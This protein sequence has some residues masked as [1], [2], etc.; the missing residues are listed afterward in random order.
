[1]PRQNW[2][3]R[4]PLPPQVLLLSVLPRLV[5]MAV[6]T[7]MVLPLQPPSGLPL[8]LSLPWVL[9]LA[10]SML[11]LEV[12]PAAPRRS[13]PSPYGAP[14]TLCTPQSPLHRL[15]PPVPLAD[16]APHPE[17]YTPSSGPLSPPRPSC[18]GSAPEGCPG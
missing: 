10:L 15:L 9:A 8:S 12:V 6:W 3:P 4:S 18:R 11:L 2:D 14:T 5:T 1:M 7:L 16:L 13:P 17:E